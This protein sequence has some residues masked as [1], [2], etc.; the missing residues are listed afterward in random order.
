MAA[1]Q[2]TTTAPSDVSIMIDGLVSA[3]L[4]A[5]ADYDAFDQE[6]IDR[7]VKKAS[8][9]ALDQHATLARLAVEE[10]GRGVFEDKA[11]KNLFACEHVTHSMAKL[12]T[13]GV[14]AEDEINGIVEI[15]DPVG[16]VAGITPVTNPTSTTIFK[17]LM[18]LKTRNPIVFAFHPAAQRCSAQAARV[19]RDA[20]VA[21]GAPEHCIQWIEQPSMRATAALMNHPGVATT[22]A[23]GGNAWVGAASSWGKPARGGGAGNAPAYVERS[24]DLKRAVNDIVLSK[25]FDNGMICASEQAAIID[26]AG[27]GGARAQFGAPDPH[28]A[29]AGGRR[30]A[31]E[32]AVR[33]S[34]H[35]REG[36]GAR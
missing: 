4:K 24:A 25:S 12:R 28:R 31:E 20:A 10:T 26:A 2:S 23:T 19:V 5:L 36:C 3:G 30:K 11:V 21:A 7:I 22:L 35:G 6:Q 33:G 34:A 18:A 32:G 1:D 14:I 17:A 8:V 27:D 9:A 15:A 29:D 16:V 13:V